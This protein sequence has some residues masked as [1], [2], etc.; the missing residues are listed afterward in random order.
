SVKTARRGLELIGS[1]AA[2]DRAELLCAL[3]VALFYLGR[4]AEVDESLISLEAAARRAGHHG[5][6]SVHERIGCLIALARTGNLRAFVSAYVETLGRPHFR[7]AART[8]HAL[9]QLYLGMEEVALEQLAE[10]VREK[11]VEDLLTGMAEGN[12]CAAMAFLGHEDKARAL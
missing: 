11:P 9:A 3:V 2:W 12:L 5:A 4:F 6:L 8:Q 7:Y 1:D 10:V